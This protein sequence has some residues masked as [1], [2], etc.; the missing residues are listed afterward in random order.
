VCVRVH[1]RLIKNVVFAIA[2]LSKGKRLP[3]SL[4]FHLLV[5][6]EPIRAQ[7]VLV[8]LSVENCHFLRQKLLDVVQARAIL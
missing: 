1:S 2:S 8:H 3:Q 7:P 5:L 4:L 6:A